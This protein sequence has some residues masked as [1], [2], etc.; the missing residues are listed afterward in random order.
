[1]C[2]ITVDQTIQRLCHEIHIRRKYFQNWDS[3]TEEDLLYEAC[4]CI[5]GSQMVF[6]VA[7]AAAQ[8]LRDQGLLRPPTIFVQIENYKELLVVAMSGSF[9]ISSNGKKR[10]LRVRFK[11]R[12]AS[13]LVATL[14]RMR[15][16][17]E[18]FV[19]ILQTCS[20]S[21]FPAQ[22]ARKHLI[23][24]VCGFGPKQASLFLR[25]IGF[26]FDLAILDT[27][28]ID[29][30]RA[31]RGIDLKPSALS[32]LRRYEE[33]EAEFRKIAKEFGYPVGCVDLAMWV[34]VRVAKREAVWCD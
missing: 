5:F 1:M 26:C 16:Q 3:Y 21:P 8:T 33:I 14:A 13:L 32:Q 30:L 4:V 7:E 18:T 9:S 20:H 6:E 24:V 27:H 23:R 28:I 11:N 15:A 25:R 19:K 2:M 34:T 29:Y 17:E 10:K 31:K 12:S 22:E